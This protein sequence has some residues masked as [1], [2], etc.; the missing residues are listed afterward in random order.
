[1][2]IAKKSIFKNNIIVSNLGKC[3]P[4]SSSCWRWTTGCR[5]CV[6][7][8]GTRRTRF[9]FQFFE[10]SFGTWSHT[11]QTR[12]QVR[13][14]FSVSKTNLR[15]AKFH[16]YS[17]EFI[18]SRVDLVCY[19]EW[20]YVIG[21]LV[22]HWAQDTCTYTIGSRSDIRRRCQRGL[23]RVGLVGLAKSL[24]HY[25]NSVRALMN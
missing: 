19:N 3:G 15:Y 2:Y 23:A 12:P 11:D 24:A 17:T 8:V 4:V 9:R 7:N 18:M 10:G 20:R 6:T 25:A 14:I 5:W 22:W 21:C 1:M 16:N 13:P